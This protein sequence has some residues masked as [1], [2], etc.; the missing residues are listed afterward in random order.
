MGDR[1]WL[2]AVGSRAGDI[3]GRDHVPDTL[4]RRCLVGEGKVGAIE[5]VEVA[6]PLV[7]EALEKYARGQGISLVAFKDFCG[8]R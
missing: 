5:P 3:A 1:V 6:I 8:K 2:E 7:A 4:A